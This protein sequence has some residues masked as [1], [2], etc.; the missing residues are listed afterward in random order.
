VG[1]VGS[2][3]VPDRVAGIAVMNA[4]A[5]DLAGHLRL[6]VPMPRK[7][8]LFRVPGPAHVSWLL[9]V[10]IPLAVTEQRGPR[11]EPMRAGVAAR[12]WAHCVCDHHPVSL[13]ASKVT[14]VSPAAQI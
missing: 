4:S 8:Q 12:R 7:Y 5:S 6:A 13:L 1:I 3:A 10:E 9:R 2:F 11:H 14:L